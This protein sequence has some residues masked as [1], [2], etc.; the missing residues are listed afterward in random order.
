MDIRQL[1]QR[2]FQCKN[3]PFKDASLHLYKGWYV[4]T[5]VRPSIQ[6]SLLLSVTCLLFLRTR[7]EKWSFIAQW[8][9]KKL[10]LFVS[11]SCDFA[12]PQYFWCWTRLG[13]SRFPKIL[14]STQKWPVLVNILVQ[15]TKFP[16]RAAGSGPNSRRRLFGSFLVSNSNFIKIG[17]LEALLWPFEPKTHFLKI[18]FFTWGGISPKS[19]K[20]GQRC[21]MGY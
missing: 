14:G 15:T 5:S 3:E 13:S 4:R 7:R 6:P 8:G 10:R 20:L 19:I 12:C 2:K 1:T 9:K 16:K 21:F 18:Q 11:R 17:S